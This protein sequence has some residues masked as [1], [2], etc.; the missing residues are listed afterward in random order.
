VASQGQLA[1]KIGQAKALLQQ[2]RDIALGDGDAILGNALNNLAK[3]ADKLID[4]VNGV[5]E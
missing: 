1:A 5:K 3:D 2:G 4:L